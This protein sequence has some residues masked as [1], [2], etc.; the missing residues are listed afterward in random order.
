MPRRLF[1]AGDQGYPSVSLHR[2][3][4]FHLFTS[5]T[6]SKTKTIRRS[7]QYA[8]Q[9]PVE[10]EDALARQVALRIFASDAK[11]EEKGEK[12]DDDVTACLIIARPP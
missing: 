7:D 5:S 11:E 1:F 8:S 10:C 6:L 12:A 9:C 3:L 2:F 4:F